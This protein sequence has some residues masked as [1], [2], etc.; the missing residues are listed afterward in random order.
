MSIFYTCLEN[1]LRSDGTRGLL[2]D[3]YDEETYGSEE[4]AEME[5]IAKYH[6]VAAAA[7]KSGLPYHAAAIWSSDGRITKQEIFDRRVASNPVEE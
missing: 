6:T 3:H 5:A 7:A 2:Y 1:Q 4:N